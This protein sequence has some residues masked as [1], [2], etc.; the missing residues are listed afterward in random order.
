MSDISAGGDFNPAVLA[1]AIAHGQWRVARRARLDGQPVIE[2]TETSAGP[3]HPLPVELWVNAQT[4][5][6]LRC[7]GGGVSEVFGYLPPTVANRAL[8][9]VPIPRGFP[10]SD[11]FSR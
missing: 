9:Q 6:P 8:L 11:P 1:Q 2:L 3:V 7:D 4:Y 10:R 5:L